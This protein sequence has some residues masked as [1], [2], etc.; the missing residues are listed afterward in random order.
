MNRFHVGIRIGQDL[1]VAETHGQ[2]GGDI[3]DGEAITD[4]E[5]ASFLRKMAIENPKQAAALI[6][7]TVDRVLVDSNRRTCGER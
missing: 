2:I 3:G 7:I 6:D 4:H 5:V 1:L